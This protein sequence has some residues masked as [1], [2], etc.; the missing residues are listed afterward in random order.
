M[1]ERSAALALRLATRRRELEPI[2][3]F[4]AS[5]CCVGLAAPP[6]PPPPLR[7]PPML[8]PMLTLMLADMLGG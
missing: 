6:A 7:P 1:L 2:G 5:S 3:F 4:G 8:A